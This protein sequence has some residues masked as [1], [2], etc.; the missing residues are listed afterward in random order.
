ML[1]IPNQPKILLLP[2]GRLWNGEKS[3]DSRLS[4]FV[5]L[6]KTEK[7][8]LIKITSPLLLGNK[9]QNK[10]IDSSERLALFFV[11]ESGQYLE[12]ILSVDGRFSVSGFDQPGQKVA[13]LNNFSFETNHQ[14][15]EKGKV[16]NEIIIPFDL[17]P[18][19]LT[20]LNAFLI[21]GSQILAYHPLSGSEPNLHQP[22]TFPLAKIE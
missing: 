7:G 17:F 12:V 18:A 3:P 16:L 14:E 1:V 19:E 20:A 22:A 21:V 9:T 13:D 15:N 4:S 6:Q 5:E 2:I 11:E 10:E 8:V